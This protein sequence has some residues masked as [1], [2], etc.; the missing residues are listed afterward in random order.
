MRRLDGYM[1]TGRWWEA[2]IKSGAFISRTTAGASVIW[3][4]NGLEHRVRIV[5]QLTVRPPLLRRFFAGLVREFI[6]DQDIWRGSGGLGSRKV[7]V[8][9]K[10][11]LWPRHREAR[12][13]LDEEA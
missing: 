2:A 12:V 13:S 8:P 1:G 9:A 5:E 7:V 4:R 3:G 6:R 10:G 11:R